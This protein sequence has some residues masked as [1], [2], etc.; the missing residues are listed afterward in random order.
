MLAAGVGPGAQLIQ[1]AAL[2]QQLGQPVGGDNDSNAS[3]S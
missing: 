2:G 3:E 1:L